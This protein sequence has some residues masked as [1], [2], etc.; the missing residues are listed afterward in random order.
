LR[1]ELGKLPEKGILIIVDFSQASQTKRLEVVSLETEKTILY[2]RVTH[3]VNSGK[4][5][6]KELSNTVGSLQS[7]AGL[8]W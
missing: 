5:Y 4:V 6:T 2:G 1:K 7:S 3:G 8:F